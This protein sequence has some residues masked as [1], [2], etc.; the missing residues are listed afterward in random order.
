M[1]KRF[2][3]LLFDAGGIF[4]LPDPISLGAI[5]QEYGGNGS[6]AAMTRAHYAGM[7]ALDNAAR[8]SDKD[9]IDGFSWDPY[10]HAYFASA[11][12]SGA[13]LA[14][15]EAKAKNMFSPF[16]WRYP[17]LESAAALWRMHLQGLPVGIVSNASGQVEATLANQCICQVGIGAGV[18][19]LI[20]T[21]SHVIGTAK[22]HAGIFRDA[23]ALLGSM[24]IANNRIAYIGDSYVNDVQGARNADIHPILLDPYNDHESDDCERIGSL[25]D[26][27]DFI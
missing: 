22:P 25:H 6:I 21:D 15:A 5:V 24:G 20:V 1:S 4:L 7:A 8:S 11:G 17:I 12:L 26:L 13:S 27:L 18:P 16:L 14:E 2:D 10:R 23:L 19:V 3:A 9:T